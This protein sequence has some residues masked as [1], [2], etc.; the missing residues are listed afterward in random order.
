MDPLATAADEVKNV[1]CPQ[2]HGVSVN[3]EA[4]EA[5]EPEWPAS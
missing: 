3:P 1:S 2:Q 4:V 5:D